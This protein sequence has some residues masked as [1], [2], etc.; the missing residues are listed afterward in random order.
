VLF[1]GSVV[2][3]L[4]YHRKYRVKNHIDL[5]ALRKRI[6]KEIKEKREWSQ[7][8]THE[9]ELYLQWFYRGCATSLEMLLAEIE[10]KNHE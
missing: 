9:S 4:L 8:Y 6:K 5:E 2:L 1:L 3:F 10:V 7:K